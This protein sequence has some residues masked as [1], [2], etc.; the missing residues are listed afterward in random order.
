MNVLYDTKKMLI[1]ITSLFSTFIAKYNRRYYSLYSFTEKM[2]NSQ[3]EYQT[4][5]FIIMLHFLY[6]KKLS[7]YANE[8]DK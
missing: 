8:F 6:S 5:D 3:E 4:Y 1:L 7:S 2:T